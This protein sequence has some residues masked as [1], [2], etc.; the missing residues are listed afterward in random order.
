[1]KGVYDAR[2]LNILFLF[3]RSLVPDQKSF[4]LEFYGRYRWLG[5]SSE[6]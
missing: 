5:L 4:D 2:G 3:C 6:E 1:M